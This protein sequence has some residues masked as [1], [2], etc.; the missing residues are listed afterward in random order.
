LLEGGIIGQIAKEHLVHDHTVHGPS[1]A[2]TVHH[3]GFSFRDSAG[4]TYWD[5]RLMDDE[6]NNICSLYCCYTGKKNYY[7]SIHLL[8]RLLQ[9]MALRCWKFLVP[10]T[11]EE[12]IVGQQSGIPGAWRK[13]TKRVE[14]K[15]K[16]FF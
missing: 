11:S 14:D 8:L 9:A 2:V 13:V 7:T 6:I 4:I 15:S 10:R 5:D 12:Y 1:T 16:A 3:Q